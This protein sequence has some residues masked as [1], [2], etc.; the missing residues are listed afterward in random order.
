MCG[1]FV[2]QLDAHDLASMGVPVIAPFGPRYNIA[3]TQLVPV[4]IERERTRELRIM[5]WG[6]VPSWATDSTIGNRLINA[7]AESLATKPAFREAF[8]SR[9]CLVPA[10][11][12]YEWQQIAGARRKQPYAVGR[13]DGEPFAFAGLWERWAPRGG[14]E[15]LETFTI[16]TC[17]AKGLLAQQHN[18]MPVIL[19]PSAYE[20]WLAPDTPMAALEALL[21]PRAA[22]DL[23]SYPVSPSVNDPRR[24]DASCVEPIDVGD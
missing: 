13:P 5:R 16:I 12:F 1:R 14:G 11:S 24:D 6:L 10:T 4:V 8:R 9:R 19:P 22:D 7:R 3:P 23:R 15:P 2:L 21:V 18:R 17:N 20:A